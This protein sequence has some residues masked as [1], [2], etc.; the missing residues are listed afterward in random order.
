MTARQDL[1]SR[2]I[3]KLCMR[4][5]QRLGSSINL[6]AAVAALSQD[7]SCEVTL[8]KACG[9]LDKD[10]FNIGTT[11]MLQSAGSAWRVAKHIP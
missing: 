4:I 8:N 1:I 10:D 2:N 11:Y 3:N 7:V 5:S 9:S 6:G